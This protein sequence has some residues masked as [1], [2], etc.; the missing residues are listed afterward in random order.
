MKVI[1][2][3]AEVFEEKLA[4]FIPK[5][6][7]ILSKKLKEN[8]PQ[9]HDTLSASIGSLVSFTVRHLELDAGFK[10]L[11]AVF[12]MLFQ[13]CSKGNRYTQIGSAMCV[14]KVIQQ[15]PFEFLYTMVDD[16]TA[17]AIEVLRQHTCKAHIQLF[18]CLLSLI[19]AFEGNGDKLH[20]SAKGILPIAID[21]LTNGDWN[22]RK[23]AVELIYTLSMLV[24]EAI[25]PYKHELLD[26][27]GHCRFDKVRNQ[28]LKFEFLTH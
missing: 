7:Q 23:I 27:L 10:N 26:V 15:S 21:N 12:T 6:L 19:L 3:M 17:K 20:E 1:G 28:S 13:L 25:R 22:V 14:T 18:E 5:I 8:D 2:I 11:Q 9:M 4:N 24:P 16:I